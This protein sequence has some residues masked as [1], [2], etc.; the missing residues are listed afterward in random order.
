M[1]KNL[2]HSYLFFNGPLLLY[3]TAN[4]VEHSD[5]KRTTTP[6]ILKNKELVIL[7]GKTVKGKKKA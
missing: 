1:T 5:S 3:S 4:F 7:E 2:Q 6:K